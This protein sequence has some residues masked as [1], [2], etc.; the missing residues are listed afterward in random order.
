MNVVF[1]LVFIVA[2]VALITIGIRQYRW[3]RS[4][5]DDMWKHSPDMTDAD[6]SDVGKG[7]VAFGVL[8][9]VVVI[10]GLFV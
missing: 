9:L 3:P 6:K 4:L 10:I 8:I 5:P 7:M 2:A 1:S